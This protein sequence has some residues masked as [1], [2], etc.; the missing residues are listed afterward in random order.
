MTTLQSIGSNTT[1]PGLGKPSGTGILQTQLSRYET[2]LADWCSCPSGKTSEGKKK[3]TDIQQKADAVKLAIR[4]IE[5][6]RARQTTASA[7]VAGAP[8]PS[9]NDSTSLVGSRVDVYA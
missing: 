4:K 7:P 6:A 1:Q 5:D 9:R 2:Q 3:I 8:Q